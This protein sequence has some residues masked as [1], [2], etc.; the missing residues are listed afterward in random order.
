V[1]RENARVD[2]MPSPFAGNSG[3]L[4]V[5]IVVHADGLGDTVLRLLR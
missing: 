2:R 4:R 3:E 1:A 5:D